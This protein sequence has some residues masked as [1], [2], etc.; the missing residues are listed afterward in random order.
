MTQRV[1]LSM[2]DR[3]VIQLHWLRS[4]Q[5]YAVW[6]GHH[7]LGLVRCKPPWPF[8]ASVYVILT[9]VTL[10]MA[11]CL[12]VTQSHVSAETVVA[13]CCQVTPTGTCRWR[14]AAGCPI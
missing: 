3:V 11:G 1:A 13:P 8:K 12:P 14:V 10:V 9:T 7:L 2:S 4:W 6:R 5:S